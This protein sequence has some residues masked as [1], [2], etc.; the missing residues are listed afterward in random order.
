ML[1]RL[2]LL[3]AWLLV[4]LARLPIRRAGWLAGRC[5]RRVYPRLLRAVPDGFRFRY[6]YEI[7]GAPPGV[8][9]LDPD[10][11]HCAPYA[12]APCGG[13][14]SCMLEQAQHYGHPVH[15]VPVAVEV[16]PW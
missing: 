12:S 5:A 7:E 14:D 6:V 11:E 10:R 16:S 8:N 9:P 4:V 2:A 13:C 3:F 1:S 15:P